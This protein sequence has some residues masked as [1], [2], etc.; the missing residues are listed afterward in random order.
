MHH[1]TPS[2]RVEC[3]KAQEFTQK[4][5]TFLGYVSPPLVFPGTDLEE[6]QTGKLHDF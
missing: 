6:I 4:G 5:T 3:G 2:D 1:A